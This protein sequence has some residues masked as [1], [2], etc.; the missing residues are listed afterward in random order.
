MNRV[1]LG[2][3]IVQRICERYGWTVS[4][5]STKVRAPE[6]LWCCYLKTRCNKTMC[7]NSTIRACCTSG[8]DIDYNQYAETSKLHICTN[9]KSV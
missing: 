1:G 5:E 9:A 3:V 2:L 6:F 4:F 7:M 8:Y